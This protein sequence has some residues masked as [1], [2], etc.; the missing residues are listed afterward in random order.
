MALY[1]SPQL[2]QAA[3]LSAEALALGRGSGDPATIVHC[4]QARHFALWQPD[5]V[6]ARLAVANELVAL[7]EQLGDRE[8]ELEGRS[9]RL[10]D[11]VESG[12]V[13]AFDPEYRAIE[14]T[15]SASRLPMYVWRTFLIRAARALCEGRL[16]DAERLGQEALAAG[17]RAEAAN[18]MQF[19]AAMVFHLRRAQERLGE[20]AP[21]VLDLAERYPALPIWRAGVA[22]LHVSLGRD[23]DAHAE[24]ERLAGGDFADI[25]RDGNWLTTMTAL[26]DVC[27]ALG[28]SA[29]SAALYE[30]LLPFAAHTV[31]VEA[32]VAYLGPVAYYLGR[33][34]TV[35]RRWDAAAAHFDVAMQMNERFGATLLLAK[36]QCAYAAMLA[37]ANDGRPDE[38]AHGYAAAALET[39]RRLGAPALLAWATSL[40]ERL[41][42]A[43]QPSEP[44]TVAPTHPVPADALFRKDGQ[45]WTITYGGTTSRLKDSR[46][47]FY[48][49]YLLQHPGREFLANDLVAAAVGGPPQARPVAGEP[50]MEQPAVRRPAAARVDVDAVLDDD[51]KAAYRTRLR[52]LKEELAEAEE[53]ND[54]GRAERAREEMDAIAQA[55]SSAIGLGGRDRQVGQ[56]VERAR[57]AVTKA[58]LLAMKTIAAHNPTLRWHLNKAI[59]TGR[60]CSYAPDASEAPVWTTQ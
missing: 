59:K 49:H 1:F 28:H 29:W 35:L 37:D 27:A 45:F 40:L 7:A 15:A 19:Y 50:A 51:A 22:L 54:I 2:E 52:D 4:L 8:A 25:R 60:F 24:I 10:V 20:L 56:P 38:R 36:T 9:W 57:I 11:L 39:A 47:L 44:G 16:D 55:L 3:V 43:P 32:M 12:V 33:L 53:F 31:V 30:R 17:Q 6:A 26:A 21:A 23:A 46:G 41:G 18:A 34:A 13:E 5:T 42:G 14:H 58:I 48:L